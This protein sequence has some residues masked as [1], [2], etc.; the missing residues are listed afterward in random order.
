MRDV[1]WAK[2][3]AA[4]RQQCIDVGVQCDVVDFAQTVRFHMHGKL[5]VRIQ[6]FRVVRR[7]GRMRMNVHQ[8]HRCS[9]VSS[10]LGNELIVDERD[11]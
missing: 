9:N 2:D 11:V 5:F 6:C 1:V 8:R 10:K 3:V 7:G 4:Y